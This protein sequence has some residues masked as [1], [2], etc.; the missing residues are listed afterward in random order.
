[1]PVIKAQG[2]RER[3]SG[4]PPPLA[5]PGQTRISRHEREREREK[6]SA[7]LCAET[8]SRFSVSDTKV[9]SKQESRELHFLFPFLFPFSFFF[10]FSFKPGRHP[11]KIQR[12]AAARSTH[13]F[14]A[15]EPKT[16]ENPMFSFY[17]DDK[18]GKSRYVRTY[19]YSPL[20]LNLSAC[21]IPT[22]NNKRGD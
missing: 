17:T 18:K 5:V 14:F 12:S 3:A 7:L 19:G 13:R 10:F 9:N 1:M 21:F 22:R 2:A 11:G 4:V 16:R 15:I 6:L 20:N 8:G